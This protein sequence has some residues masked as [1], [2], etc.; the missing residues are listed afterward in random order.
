MSPHC[1]MG[2]GTPKVGHSAVPHR[3][4][5]QD[6][7]PGAFPEVS[8]CPWLCGCNPRP[9]PPHTCPQQPPAEAPR[10]PPGA[11]EPHAQLLRFHRPAPRPPRPSP[12]SH[13]SGEPHPRAAIGG[14]GV[15]GAWPSWLRNFRVAPRG[16]RA[17]SGVGPLR[18]AR[19]VGVGYRG[20]LP[21]WG[22]CWREFLTLFRGYL[23][24]FYALEFI[25]FFLGGRV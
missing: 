7:R 12:P 13:W 21:F 16:L 23:C 15:K 10:H 3:S 2:A 18:E 17:A 5:G 9:C 8:S 11:H 1:S 25:Y 24:S 6:S 4:I 19:G 20:P 22:T 14:C